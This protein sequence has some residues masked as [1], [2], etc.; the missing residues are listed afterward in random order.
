MEGESS[1]EEQAEVEVEAAVQASPTP[2][3]MP[4]LQLERNNCIYIALHLN[5]YSS[6]ATEYTSL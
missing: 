4:L 2:A 6:S 3:V 5:F 1:R